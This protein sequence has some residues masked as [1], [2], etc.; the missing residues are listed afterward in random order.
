MTVPFGTRG[1]IFVFNLMKPKKLMY[2]FLNFLF[3]NYN[4]FLKKN[5]AVKEFI[6]Q[7]LPKIIEI[8]P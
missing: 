3:V 8:H 4:F 7:I 1:Y 2:Q 5:I 6:N